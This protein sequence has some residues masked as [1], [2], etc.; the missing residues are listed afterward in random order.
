MAEVHFTNLLAVA[1]VG[2]LAPLVLGFLP[3]C[4]FPPWLWRS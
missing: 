1:A 3:P 2:M 4:G